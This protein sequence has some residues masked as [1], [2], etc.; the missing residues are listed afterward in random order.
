MIQIL[1]L[2]LNHT[3]KPR[4]AGADSSMPILVSTLRAN[5]QMQKHTPPALN[6][7]SVCNYLCAVQKTAFVLPPALSRHLCVR[8]GRR[9][10]LKEEE[11]TQ[12]T[13]SKSAIC[14]L[15][16]QGKLVEYVLGVLR[17]NIVLGHH[18]EASVNVG[19]D[20]LFVESDVI[21]VLDSH[22]AHVE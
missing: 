5:S 21:G 15:V 1:Y 8:R 22:I 6:N 17:I 10:E 4:I 14:D 11:N 7:L 20:G 18:Q 9:S 12:C 16:Q 13:I 3:S 2:V 19:R